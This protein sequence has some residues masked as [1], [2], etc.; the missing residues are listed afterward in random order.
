LRAKLEEAGVLDAFFAAD[1]LQE[2][3]EEFA[4]WLVSLGDDEKQILAR[5][6]I[7]Y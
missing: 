7:T 4:P 6:K 3:D 5:C 2:D 1:F